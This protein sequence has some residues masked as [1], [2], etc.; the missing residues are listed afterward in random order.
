[1]IPEGAT[2]SSPMWHRVA[3]ALARVACQGSMFADSNARVSERRWCSSSRKVANANVGIM[4]QLRD[5]AVLGDTVI[6]TVNKGLGEV[7]VVGC[8]Q[9]VS[10]RLLGEVV[11]REKC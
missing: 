7:L 10:V 4:R 9:D 2:A 5:R 11:D 3:C 1:M 6:E 8:S